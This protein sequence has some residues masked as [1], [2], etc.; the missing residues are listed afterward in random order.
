MEE[1]KSDSVEQITSSNEWHDQQNGISPST[2]RKSL[3]AENT[4]QAISPWGH[5]PEG[6]ANGTTHPPVI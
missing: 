5:T 1:S 2:S 3:K 6:S 4:T